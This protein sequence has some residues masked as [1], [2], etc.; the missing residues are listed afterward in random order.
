MKENKLIAEFMGLKNHFKNKGI[1]K[2]LID[3]D[4]YIQDWECYDIKR[5]MLITP[6]EMK[7]HNNWDWL[8]PVVHKIKEIDSDFD[9]LERG[10][11]IDEVHKESVEFIKQLNK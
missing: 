10:L 8:L 5:D 1:T 11:S 9:A 4:E 7:Y 2:A 3:G 6:I